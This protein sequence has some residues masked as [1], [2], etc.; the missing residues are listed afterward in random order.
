MVHV[1]NQYKNVSNI[2]LVCLG[3]ISTY[4]FCL[5][6][7]VQEMRKEYDINLQNRQLFDNCGDSAL[8]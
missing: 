6:L 2:M 3:N 5:K 4:V 1:K 8:Y 7:H